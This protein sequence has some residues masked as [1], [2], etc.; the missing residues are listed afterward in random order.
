MTFVQEPICELV[1]QIVYLEGGTICQLDI[2]LNYV[3]N[4]DDS[5]IYCNI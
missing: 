5:V 3:I 2:F 4:N 1:P